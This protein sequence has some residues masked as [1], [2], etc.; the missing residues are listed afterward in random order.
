MITLQASSIDELNAIWKRL[1][2]DFQV[3]EK[4]HLDPKSL[5]YRMVIK[6][7]ELTAMLRGIADKVLDRLDLYQDKALTGTITIN[8][9]DERVVQHAQ[10]YRSLEPLAR[11]WEIIS[12]TDK[13]AV[14]SYLRSQILTD[15]QA[16]DITEG[17]EQ[18][19]RL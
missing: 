1:R 6:Q 19:N 8:Q 4:I 12:L 10:K 2:V 9:F 14:F 11:I 18:T 17:N 13:R 5:Q 16:K 3:I 7:P 15:I